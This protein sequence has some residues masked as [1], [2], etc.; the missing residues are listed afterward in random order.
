MIFS[1]IMY[2]P[3]P[4]TDGRN[5]EFV[6]LHNARSVFR[7]LTGWRLT[8][9]VDYR[10]PD[11]FRLQAGETV[12]VA[13]S[14]DD[15][16]AVSGITHVL[17]P[18]TGSLPNDSGRI[19]LRNNADAIRLDVEYFDAPPWPASPDGAGH[20]LVL[21]RPSYG[22]ADPRAWAASEFRGG[23]PGELDPTVPS[24][25][26]SLVINEFLAHTDDPVLDFIE[27]YNRSNERVELSGL[28][29]TDGPGDEPVSHPRRHVHRTAGLLGLGSEPA[30][31]RV[32]CRGRNAL[33]HQCPRHA[34]ARCR[35]LRGAGERRRQRTFPGRRP[36]DPA[37]DA[38]H[39]GRGQRRLAAR[40]RGDQRTHV[41]PHLGRRRRRV[42]RAVQPHA[43]A[44]QPP[45][46]AVHRGVDFTFPASATLPANGYLVVA[47]NAARL[48]ANYPPTDQRELRRQL[49]GQLGDRGERLACPGQTNS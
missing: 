20:S 21:A 13:A 45:R 15:L 4:R 26:T 18:Y 5:L 38:A 7:D 12:V 35:P 30:P 8:G 33:P 11:R 6:E 23:S 34:R 36:G 28:V 27:L 43:S 46:L 22:E 29:L 41:Q 16:Q 47:R 44:D 17:G 39:T 24:P 10:F 31:L 49:R 19:R 14:P 2:H 40:G 3:A 42:H 48:R 32:E 9:A 1:E 37:A 25:E